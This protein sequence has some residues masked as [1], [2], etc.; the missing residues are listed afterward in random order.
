MGPRGRKRSCSALP[1]LFVKHIKILPGRVPHYS[2]M[3]CFNFM[4]LCPVRWGTEQ[5]GK[6]PARTSRNAA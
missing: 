1:F 2:Y 4:L 3:Y 6:C 5:P